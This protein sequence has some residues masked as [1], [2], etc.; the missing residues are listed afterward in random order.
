M[1]NVGSEN[2]SVIDTQ[3]C[4]TR[5][6]R[7]RMVDCGHDETSGQNHESLP[8]DN[9]QEEPNFRIEETSDLYGVGLVFR[10]TRD[11]KLVVSSFIRD[12]SAFECGLVRD[13]GCTSHF[14]VYPFSISC[15]SQAPT[16]LSP[17][18]AVSCSLFLIYG[19][20]GSTKSITNSLAIL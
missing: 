12:S 14:P 17:S 11:G 16:Q 13:G 1:G 8:Y 7:D 3:C 6:T 18:H 5:N 9:R 10:T 15:T 19:F 20:R 2:G 4:A